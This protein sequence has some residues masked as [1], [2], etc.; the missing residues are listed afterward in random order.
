MRRTDLLDTKEWAHRRMVLGMRSKTPEWRLKATFDMCEFWN[1][2]KATQS[3]KLT[4]AE[5]ER[6]APNSK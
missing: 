3:S 6:R 2:Q 1:D 4:V 5:D